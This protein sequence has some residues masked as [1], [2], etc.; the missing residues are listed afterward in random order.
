MP[1]N[2][3]GKFDPRTNH[4]I[5]RENSISNIP[6]DQMAALINNIANATIASAVYS[7]SLS[8]VEKNFQDLEKRLESLRKCAS[9]KVK[10][11]QLNV[12]VEAPEVK[13]NLPIFSMK[14]IKDTTSLS[15]ALPATLQE[16]AAYTTIL[17]LLQASFPKLMASIELPKRI[18]RFVFSSA[19][20]LNHESK[21]NFFPRIVSQGKV[22]Y[23]AWDSSGC[24]IA[25]G[26]KKTPCDI[27]FENKETFCGVPLSQDNLEGI[28]KGA[29][30]A[31]HFMTSKV[32][33]IGML[34]TKL[35][36]FLQEFLYGNEKSVYDYTVACD[37]DSDEDNLR[38]S[39]LRTR[40]SSSRSSHTTFGMLG[41]Q[42]ASASPYLQ[43]LPDRPKKPSEKLYPF[44]I[45]I[46]PQF[47]SEETPV[48]KEDLERAVEMQFQEKIYEQFSSKKVV[49][50]KFR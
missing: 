2:N 1:L 29:G 44:C 43:D 46:I 23:V 28:E 15:Q 31:A 19:I 20:P 17:D 33:V 8:V 24:R 27:L 14:D 18:P 25:K 3:L 49:N 7:Q 10:D 36:G 38:S 48:H 11:Q 26:F 22:V 39:G 41:V 45:E 12:Y 50:V 6:A 37:S 4:S 34:I 42:G 16:P 47:S 13:R 35:P 9:F 21:G 40:G 32:T 5:S 30:V